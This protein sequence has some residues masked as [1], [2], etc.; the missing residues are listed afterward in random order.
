MSNDPMSEPARRSTPI[1]FFV[2]GGVLLASIACCAGAGGLGWYVFASYER[3]VI[4]QNGMYPGLP[5]NSRLITLRKPYDAPAD[6]QRGD[7]IV[8]TH[9]EDGRQT[10]YIWRVV[11]LPGDKIETS[12]RSVK[13][14]GKELPLVKKRVDGEFVIFRETN[15]SAQYEIAYEDNP[16]WLPPDIDVVV[17]R[18]HFFVLG[19]NRHQAGKDSRTIGTIP[20]QS[21]RGKKW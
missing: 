13:V 21:I 2:L 19:D 9:A 8:F 4:P 5:A 10:T 18:D 6:V 7:I 14:N 3:F 1:L 11:G 12:L 16:R 20:F 15:G 17:P